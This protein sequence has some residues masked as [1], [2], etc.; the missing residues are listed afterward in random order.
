MLRWFGVGDYLLCL[1]GLISLV[2]GMVVLGLSQTATMV[3]VSTF[4]GVGSKLV[5]SILRALI[6]QVR[7]L[8]LH[9]FF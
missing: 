9:F 8:R 6:S 7:D 5:D 2:L 4:V 3:F 1:G